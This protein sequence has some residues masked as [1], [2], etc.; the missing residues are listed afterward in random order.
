MAIEH[1]LRYPNTW[2][3]FFEFFLW[4][5]SVGYSIQIHE[6]TSLSFFYGNWALVTTS[7][8]YRFQIGQWPS[9]LESLG[10][11]VDIWHLPFSPRVERSFMILFLFSLSN[12]LVSFLVNDWIMWKY[13]LLIHVVLWHLK[14]MDTNI[15]PTNDVQHKII[16]KRFNNFLKNSIFF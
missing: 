2:K 14:E 7:L 4:Q 8:A 1:W 16:C 13:F 9:L 10:V 6:E 3:N 11:H 5:L 12:S 15:I